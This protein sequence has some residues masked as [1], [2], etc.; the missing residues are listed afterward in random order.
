MRR[1]DFI[2]LLSGAAV[3]WPFSAR[4]QQPERVRR[5]GVLSALAEDDPESVARRAAFEKALKALN[6]TNGSNLRIDYRWGV[7]DAERIRKLA[8]EIIAL[9][10]DV[11]LISGSII[12]TPM[13]HAT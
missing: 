4:A 1:R 9:E 2:T 12:V 5:I 6:W 7:N 10:P 8:A 13:M 3:V 11:I